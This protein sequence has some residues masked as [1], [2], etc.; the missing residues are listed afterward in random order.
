MAATEKSND[1]AWAFVA[2]V[3]FGVPALIVGS[4]TTGWANATDWMLEHRIMI[5]AS[6]DPVLTLPATDGAGLDWLRIGIVFGAF[7]VLT[8]TIR[9]VAGAVTAGVSHRKPAS[10]RSAPAGPRRR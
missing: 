10:R 9:L 8:L 4:A 5:P 6:A 2:A 3:L 1:L 7:V